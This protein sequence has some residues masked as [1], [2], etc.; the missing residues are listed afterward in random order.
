[1]TASRICLWTVTLGLG[2]PGR[3]CAADGCKSLAKHLSRAGA[4]AGIE[5]LAVLPFVPLDGSAASEGL[6]LSER[7]TTWIAYYGK[8]EVIERTL[9]PAIL[10]EHSLRLT[11]ALDTRKR[12]R[13]GRVLEVKAV[14]TGSFSILKDAI[15]VNARLVDIETGVVLGARNV[16][17]RK[18]LLEDPARARPREASVP[19][20]ARLAYV[21]GRQPGAERSSRFLPGAPAVFSFEGEDAPL[22]AAA[23][24][25]SCDGAAERIDSLQAS[26]LGL[27][28]RHWAHELRKAGLPARSVKPDTLM[29]DPLMRGRFRRLLERAIESDAPP[30]TAPE[31]ERFIPADAEA[32][33]LHLRCGEGP[34]RSHEDPI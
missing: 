9:L 31:T 33:L 26:I 8:M 23:A 13:I 6:A 34:S 15:E 28:A 20:A 5:R 14:V 19:R 24:A 7:L 11:G 25:D 12:G 16:R 10:R 2:L 17:L 1:M 30:L 21:D 22:R 18:R 27:K 32:F 29:R 4:K 3:A